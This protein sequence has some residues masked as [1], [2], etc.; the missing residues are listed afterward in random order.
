MAEPSGSAPDSPAGHSGAL[1]AY[2][3]Q[4]LDDLV[5]KI[6][7]EDSNSYH[8]NGTTNQHVTNCE[9]FKQNIGIQRFVCLILYFGC[10]WSTQYGFFM[11]FKS[12][13]HC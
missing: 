5:S 6:L 8:L 4:A 2:T 1:N 9:E 7:D 12:Y 11:A 3:K 13:S 10:R